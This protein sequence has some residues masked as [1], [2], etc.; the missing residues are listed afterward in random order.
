[1]SYSS[2]VKPR[3]RIRR[4]G[5]VGSALLAFLA[6]KALCGVCSGAE[7]GAKNEETG[8]EPGTA[9]GTFQ[10]NEAVLR[11]E[12]PADRTRDW[13]VQF[14]VAYISEN[15]IGQIFAG[16]RAE[17]AA[18]GQLYLLTLTKT[19]HRFKIPF[20]EG[21]LKPELEPYVT[22]T[23]VD[24]NER[25]PFPDY[26]GGIGFRWVDFP[27]NRY[28]ETTLFVGIGL[29]YSAKIYTVDRLRHPGEE[30]SH[31]KFDWP[32]QI[33]FALPRWSQHKLVLFNDHQSGGHIFDEG[34]VNSLGVAYRFEF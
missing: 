23:I 26:N 32:I 11:L 21:Y 14:G 8:L 4:M 18:G 10:Q 6:S 13:G 16:D 30:R 3:Q 33:T 17:G 9:N 25:A 5:L 2:G 29:S 28:I 34:G 19:V 31:L 27:W 22:L 1:M 24:E 7:N 15:N 12:E 20:R